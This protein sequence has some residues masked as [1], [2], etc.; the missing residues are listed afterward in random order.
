[1]T[2]NR[3]ANEPGLRDG[4]SESQYCAYDPVGNKDACQGNNSYFIRITALSNCRSSYIIYFSGDSGGPLQLF[5]GNNT[6]MASIIGVVS[7]GVGCGTKQPS[8]FT[9]VAY[10]LDWIEP[11]VWPNL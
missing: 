4:L 11:I 3:Q 9:R 5:R 10:Y 7:F 2:I 8:V 1:M 6:N